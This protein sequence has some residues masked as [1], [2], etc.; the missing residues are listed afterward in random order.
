[1]TGDDFGQLAYLVLLGVAVGG[2]FMAENRKRL[3]PTLRM[4]LVWGFIF[5]GAIAG[6]GLWSDV[7]DDLVPQQA[8]FGD[9]ARIEIPRSFDGHYYL[10][11]DVN[12]E[13][14]TFVVDTGAT[15]VVL[16]QEDAT[17]VGLSPDTLVYSG[18]ASTA[19]G[20]VRTAPVRLEDIAI[21][22]IVDRNVPA[23]VNGGEMDG[24]LLGMSYLQQFEKIEITDGQLILTR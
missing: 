17:R 3:G 6:Y 13:P 12:G 22:P 20:T 1:M 24:S 14:I 16:T 21:G 15:Q 19:N 9:D 8:V 7:S 10:R 2:W 11:A 23:V 5:L 18:S 4:A